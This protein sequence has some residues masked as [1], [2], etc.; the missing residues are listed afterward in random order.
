[1]G[2]ISEAKEIM[3][4]KRPMVNFDIRLETISGDHVTPLTQ[5]PRCCAVPFAVLVVGGC[6]SRVSFHFAHGWQ[7]CLPFCFV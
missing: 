6:P 7:F 4:L 5:V 3:R 2:V 1:M